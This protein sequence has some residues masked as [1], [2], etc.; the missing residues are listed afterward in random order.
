MATFKELEKEEEENITNAYA[1]RELFTK[2]VIAVTGTS[3]KTTT[4]S[5]IGEILGQKYIIDKSAENCNGIRGINWCIRTLF[6]LESDYWIQEIGIASTGAMKK[7]LALV[8]PHIRVLTNIQE[9]HT[10]Y[11]RNKEAYQAEKLHFLTSSPHNSTVI[12]HSDDPLISTALSTL[13]SSIKIIRCGSSE[14]DDIQLLDYTMNADAASSSARVCI[15]GNGQFS[16]R[17]NGIGKHYAENACLAIA[18]GLQCGIS[19]EVACTVLSNYTFLEGRGLIQTVQNLMIYNYGYNMVPHACL[20]NLTEFKKIPSANKLIIL[21][22]DACDILRTNKDRLYGAIL[23]EAC[24]I[25]DNIVIYTQKGIVNPLIEKLKLPVFYQ[26]EEV[27]YHLKECLID[28]APY[29]IFIQTNNTMN[30][31]A[32]LSM[33]LNTTTHNEE[34][35]DGDDIVQNIEE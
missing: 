24:G 21:G 32:L 27:Y 1:I 17:L 35:P 11:F 6:S 33:Y 30:A 14:N 5:M 25:T 23:E 29:Y 34:N 12:V 4:T 20:R 10:C 2:P 31:G 15:K 19:A 8:R 9:A 13:D 7:H 28:T 18:C 16:F 26:F 3:G 22:G